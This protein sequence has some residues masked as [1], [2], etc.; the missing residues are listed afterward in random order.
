MIGN[1]DIKRTKQIEQQV[2]K[3]D[4]FAKI[5][6]T[7]FLLACFILLS[8]GSVSFETVFYVGMVLFSITAVTWWFWAIF[9]IRYLVKLLNR[10]SKGLIDVT[11]ELAHAQQELKALV[12]EENDRS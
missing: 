10:S 8:L 11:S 4:L 3:W 2:E 1:S 9:S 7:V 12:N 6:P 5:A